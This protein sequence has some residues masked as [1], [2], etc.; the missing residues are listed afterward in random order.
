MDHGDSECDVGRPVVDLEGVDAAMGP[1]PDGLCLI[2]IT[3]P[4]RMLNVRSVIAAR[5]A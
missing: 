5:P 1:V 4:M 3:S 2:D